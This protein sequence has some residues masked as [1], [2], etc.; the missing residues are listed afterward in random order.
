MKINALKR[1]KQRAIT[2]SKN[3]LKRIK[4]GPHVELEAN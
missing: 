3:A 2:I 1:K 4:Q